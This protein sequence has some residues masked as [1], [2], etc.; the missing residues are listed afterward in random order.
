MFPVVGNARRTPSSHAM[1]LALE[2][3]AG[4]SFPMRLVF[5]V[6][7]IP[8]PVRGGHMRR[9]F[10]LLQAMPAD[11]EVHLAGFAETLDG[12]DYAELRR[13]VPCVAS[14]EAWPWSIRLRRRPVALAKA[15]TTSV[16]KAAPY[17]LAKFAD[18]TVRE[19]VARLL[20]RWAPDAVVSGLQ[21]AQHLP[22]GGPALVLDTHN[23]EHALWDEI[24]VRRRPLLQSFVRREARLL[25]QVER[26]YWQ[27]AEAVVAIC[28]EDEAAICEVRGRAGV[29]TVPVVIAD[30]RVASLAETPGRHWNVGL[31]GS[32]SWAPNEA[33]LAHFMQRMLPKLLAAGLTVRIAGPGLASGTAARLSRAGVE[34]SGTLDDLAGFYRS[35]DCVAAPY[36]QGGGVRMKVAE[37]LSYAVP[38]VGTRLAFRGLDVTVPA[39]WVQDDPDAAVAELIRIARAPEAHGRAMEQILRDGAAAHAPC[40]A[41]AQLARV[42]A[43]L[44]QDPARPA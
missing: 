18:D 21:M 28:K 15:V 4:T 27:H 32:W 43:T 24:A 33:A 20:E 14:V 42:L 8:W 35:I 31:L 25:R 2:V 12:Q 38:V 41:A 3:L 30:R 22:H 40:R 26:R 13:F 1:T 16:L 39:N 9:W 10:E 29:F 17:T 44:S 36:L 5:L 7:E 6:H 34:V 23:V 19:R 11:C 37:A